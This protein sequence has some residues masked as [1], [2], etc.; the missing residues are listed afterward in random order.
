MNKNKKKGITEKVGDLNRAGTMLLTG[1]LG[2]DHP[3][4][5]RK[6][7][8]TFR[9]V[10]VACDREKVYFTQSFRDNISGCKGCLSIHPKV[11]EFNNSHSLVCLEIIPI[12]HSESA[13]PLNVTIRCACSEC[14]KKK[15]TTMG[16][17]RG[18]VHSCKSCPSRFPSPGDTNDSGSLTVIS[19]LGANDPLS[20]GSGRTA[21]MCACNG[22]SC[23]SEGPYQL[24]NYYR[25]CLGCKGCLS[26]YPQM[27]ETNESGTLSVLQVIPGDH[28]LS[29]HPGHVTLYCACNGCDRGKMYHVSS[30][31]SNNSFCL[32]CRPAH[33]SSGYKWYVDTP[34][35]AI[36]MRSSWEIKYSIF[37]T[38]KG[39]PWEYEPKLWDCPTGSYM[40]DFYLP[41]TDTYVEVKGQD[42][43]K[44]KIKREWLR[45]QG[46]T[47]EMVYEDDMKELG[48]FPESWKVSVRRA[49]ELNITIEEYFANAMYMH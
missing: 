8:T 16:K 10:C 18:Q 48:L 4:T 11:G 37:L 22:A 13:H 14:G 33:S 47:I 41:D 49:S 31:Y 34:D 44:Q 19:V 23:D 27:G 7:R 20:N 42:N 25:N 43:E 40:P 24:S 29:I 38:E 12:G 28:E 30:F 26:K 15:V 21:V 45:T 46:V 36:P 17:F 35:G 3:D 5:G 6:G 9:A 1:I 32:S 2:P 39:I